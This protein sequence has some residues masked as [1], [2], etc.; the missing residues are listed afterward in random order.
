MAVRN[1]SSGTMTSR[2]TQFPFRRLVMRP[3]DLVRINHNIRNETPEIDVIQEGAVFMFVGPDT[4]FSRD[5]VY[6]MTP[7]GLHSIHVC[8]LEKLDEIG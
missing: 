1:M 7:F 6:I 2:H 4:V 3:G 5:V 8:Y